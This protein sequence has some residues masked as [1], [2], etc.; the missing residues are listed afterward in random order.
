MWTDSVAD[1][2]QDPGFGRPSAGDA[3]AEIRKLAPL[4]LGFG[5][6]SLL[7]ARS[8]A[9]AERVLSEALDAGLRYFDTARSYGY[10]RAERVLGAA[11][12]GRRDEVVVVSKAGILPPGL[13]ARAQAKL[14]GRLSGTAREAHARSGV[15]DV[16][17]LRRSVETSLRQLKTDYLDIFLL[18]DCTAADLTDEVAALLS[19]LRS[20]GKARACGIATFAPDAA[21]IVA[22]RP[23]ASDVVQGPAFEGL[24]GGPATGLVVTHS[25][26]RPHLAAGGGRGSIAGAVEQLLRRAIGENP[27]GIVLFSSSS[28]RSMDSNV[29]LARTLTPQP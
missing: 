6:A 23:W 13:L 4:P 24:A 28:R 12:A 20:E 8:E 19:D 15:F 21:A 25:V 26:L 27:G 7:Q 1:S 16:P 3:L 18:H 17:A 22:S 29:A 14:V 5:C 9:Q 11:I 10:G 2:R